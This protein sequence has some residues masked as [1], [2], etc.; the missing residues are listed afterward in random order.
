MVAYARRHRRLD[1]RFARLMGYEVDG[2][3]RDFAA[4]GRR[5]PTDPVGNPASVSARTVRGAASWSGCTAITR[6]A[7]PT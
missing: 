1:R 2:S 4:L 5:S 7:T 6:C 3:D